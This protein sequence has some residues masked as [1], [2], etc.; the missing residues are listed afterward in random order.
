ME[1]YE[2]F[3]RPDTCKLVICDSVRH[4]GKFSVCIKHLSQEDK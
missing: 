4:N 2:M 3:I 1:L